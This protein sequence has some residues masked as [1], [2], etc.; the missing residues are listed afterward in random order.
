[1][2]IFSILLS[3]F[4]CGK[5]AHINTFFPSPVPL[6]AGE[7]LTGLHMTRQGMRSGLCYVMSVE[8]E[9]IFLKMTN[10]HPLEKEYRFNAKEILSKNE[11]CAIKSTNDIQVLRDIEEA[12]VDCG[13]VGWDGFNETIIMKNVTDTGERY[14]IYLRFSG[15]ST[16]SVY[17]IDICPD[18]FNEVFNRI[19]AIFR[20]TVKWE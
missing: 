18:R 16:V 7:T 14:E 3:L 8:G 15:G 19:A 11:K 17:G 5:K 13:T 10:C 2:S 1:M 9:D 12:L 20:R 6:P 4:E